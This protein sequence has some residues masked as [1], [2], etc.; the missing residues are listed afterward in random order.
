MLLPVVVVPQFGGDEDILPLH[1]TV[2]N[3]ASNPFTSFSLVLIIVCTI[4]EPIASFYGLEKL[5]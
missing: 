1:Q 4:E 3:R 5:H 2:S